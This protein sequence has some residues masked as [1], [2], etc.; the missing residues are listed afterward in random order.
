MKETKRERKFPLWL[1]SNWVSMIINNVYMAV[2]KTYDR[3]HQA[4]DKAR[5]ATTAAPQTRILNVVIT[6]KASL[7]VPDWEA[8]LAEL[9][10]VGKEVGL[11]TT[12]VTIPVGT[13][14]T[15]LL[16]AAVLEITTG[17]DELVFDGDEVELEPET[18]AGAATAME[19]SVRLPTPQRTPSFVPGVL[20]FSG[21]VV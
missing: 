19:G 12:G 20:A 11:V 15:M 8:G 2:I 4:N 21:G 7:V 17:T 9:A 14:V 3:D 5:V 6:P 18:K 16:P 1:V 13:G 10:D